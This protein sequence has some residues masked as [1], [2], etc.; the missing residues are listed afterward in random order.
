MTRD[1]DDDDDDDD[2]H[3]HT[4]RFPKS[5]GTSSVSVISIVLTCALCN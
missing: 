3:G 4:C 2:E 1:D 5:L